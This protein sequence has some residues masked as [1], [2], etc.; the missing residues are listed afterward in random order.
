SLSSA[1]GKDQLNNLFVEFD[2]YDITGM[3]QI[4]GVAVSYQPPQKLSPGNYLLRLVERMPNGKFVELER[5]EIRIAG[6][7]IPSKPEI[8]GTLDG[9]LRQ[10]LSDNLEGRLD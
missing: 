7:G 9:Q 6:P 2:G 10:T 1:I 5:W 3:V 8:S 4:N